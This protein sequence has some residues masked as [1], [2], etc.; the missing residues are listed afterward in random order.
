MKK[1]RVVIIDQEDNKEVMNDE[2]KGLMM[3][4]SV[5]EDHSCEVIMSESVP[6]M[7]EMMHSSTKVREAAKF[8]VF[9]DGLIKERRGRNATDEENALLDILEGGIQ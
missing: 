9:M 2:F 4:A 6:S 7:A 8:M 1:Y 3:L 5:D